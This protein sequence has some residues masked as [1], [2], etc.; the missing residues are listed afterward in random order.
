MW[1]SNSANRLLNDSHGHPFI[2]F[3]RA[4]LIK[5]LY[6]TLPNREKY[7]IPGKKITSVRE[8]DAA[9]TVTCSD[10]SEYS[11][12]MLAGC[13]GVHSAVR[14]LAVA[15]TEKP[16]ESKFRCLFGV[17][18]L[19]EGLEPCQM[20]E[21]HDSGILFQLFV[22]DDRVFFLVH[23]AKGGDCATSLPQRYGEEDCEA[24]AQ[25]YASHSI[26]KDGRSVFGDLWRIRERAGLYDL[27]EGVAEKWHNGRV[28][29]LGD[30]VHKVSC[31]D[32]RLVEPLH[33]SSSI[34]RTPKIAP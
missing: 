10:G 34:D 9:V 29:L 6:E 16:F 27:E 18:P 21:T 14:R 12:D 24:M 2:L 26:D 1:T 23:E 19:L 15:E 11:A 31:M 33:R 20:V 4:E 8:T 30:T 28:V 17:A 22:S 7:V 3:G 32:Q 25:R 5:M 13:D